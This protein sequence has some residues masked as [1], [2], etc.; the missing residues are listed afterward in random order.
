MVAPP[1]RADDVRELELEAERDD[2]LELFNLEERL[3]ADG[4]REVEEDCLDDGPSSRERDDN[5]RR[6]AVRL[7]VLRRNN[8][9]LASGGGRCQCSGP[10]GRDGPCGADHLLDPLRHRIELKRAVAE[11]LFI[12]GLDDHVILWRAE[13][14]ERDAA[15]EVVVAATAAGRGDPS[16]ARGNERRRGGGIFGGRLPVKC[17]GMRH[18]GA[19]GRCDELELRRLEVRRRQQVGERE[20]RE[21][22]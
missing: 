21:G 14:G 5:R 11:R 8:R 10:S 19:S 9:S 1:P 15:V 22:R 17:A 18:A 20:A 12:G 2:W 4:R 13:E 16:G 6:L 3:V 7:L